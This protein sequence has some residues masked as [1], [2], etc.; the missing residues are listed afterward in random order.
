M[1]TSSRLLETVLSN[2][3]NPYTLKAKASTLNSFWHRA[4]LVSS[5]SPSVAEGSVASPPMDCKVAGVKIVDCFRAIQTP[6]NKHAS[7]LRAAGLK[8]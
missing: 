2:S 7:G 3:L 1:V 8:A 5:D 6:E 4:P